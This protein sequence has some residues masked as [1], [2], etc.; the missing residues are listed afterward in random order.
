MVVGVRQE[1]RGKDG[2]EEVKEEGMKGWAEGLGVTVLT[3]LIVEVTVLTQLTVGVTVLTQL[4][5]EVTVL[6]QLTLQFPYDPFP[7]LPKSA[8]NARLV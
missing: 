4:T 2:V 1:W 8:A 3:Q 7:S 6:T 5:V